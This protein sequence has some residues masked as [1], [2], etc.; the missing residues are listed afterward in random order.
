MVIQ[1]Y[2]QARSSSATMAGASTYSGA[3]G[4]RPDLQVV[5]SAQPN[6][7]PLDVTSEANTIKWLREEA[8]EGPLACYFRKGGTVVAVPSL[9]AGGGFS[10]PEHVDETDAS[11]LIQPVTAEGL[12]G[13]R[14]TTG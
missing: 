14:R 9:K 8:G 3:S 7:D 11:S 13:C 2:P 10:T 1:P 12:A 5:G 6:I 4:E